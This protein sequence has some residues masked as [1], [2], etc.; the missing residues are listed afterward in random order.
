M[1]SDM[2][3]RSVLLAI[4]TAIGCGS[5]AHDVP[6]RGA[7]PQP[8]ACHQVQRDPHPAWSGAA[9]FRARCALTVLDQTT[10][11]TLGVI[12]IEW[13]YWTIGDTVQGR[14]FCIEALGV[15]SNVAIGVDARAS[16][17][18]I[19]PSDPRAELRLA[20]Y[21]TVTGPSRRDGDFVLNHPKS[22]TRWDITTRANERTVKWESG[23]EEMNPAWSNVAL[24]VRA[25]EIAVEPVA[26]A[27]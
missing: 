1:T 12:P 5:P 24:K 6:P 20:L 27:I 3:L 4:V 8:R 7:G 26:A 21:L 9:L 15:P 11:F 23:R 19:A 18:A 25:S 2:N 14:E 17:I 13:T 16:H 10:G 22:V